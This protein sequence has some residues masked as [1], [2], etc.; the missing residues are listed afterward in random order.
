MSHINFSYLCFVRVKCVRVFIFIF[1]IGQIATSSYK[2]VK[3]HF[4]EEIMSISKKQWKL[5]SRQ[6][7]C[8]IEFKVFQTECVIPKKKK[9]WEDKYKSLE[10][11]G[12]NR[13]DLRYSGTKFKSSKL[14]IFFLKYAKKLALRNLLFD[15]MCWT[16]SKLASRLSRS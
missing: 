7:L 12:D 6:A 5:S 3:T 10:V 4:Q 2:I 8:K 11:L 1:F 15:C 16:V 14:K 9:K 13:I